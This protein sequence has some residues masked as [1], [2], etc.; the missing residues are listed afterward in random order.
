[1]IFDKVRERIFLTRRSD[2]NKWCLPGGRVEVGYA[3]Q[4]RQSDDPKNTSKYLAGVTGLDDDTM[5][6]AVKSVSG[7]W[8][9]RRSPGEPSMCFQEPSEI[10][11]IVRL[12]WSLR[13]R[14]PS[15][16]QAGGDGLC[17]AARAY[18]RQ[19][20]HPGHREGGQ[21]Q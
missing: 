15:T 10:D 4:A 11:H 13:C 9:S 2:N 16:G 7:R 17:A 8:K 12:P 19:R 18:E 6:A 3:A 1:M 5:H 14:C 20:A 21:T